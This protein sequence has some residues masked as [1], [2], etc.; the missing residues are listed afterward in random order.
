MRMRVIV[1][2][3]AAL[4]WA[5]G[6]SNG[7]GP[8]GEGGGGGGAT[9]TH[10]GGALV[11]TPVIASR[12]FA[13]AVSS[14]GVVFVG[15]QDAP[16]V[17]V[18]SL[19]G[20]TF[21]DSVRVGSD[22]TDIAFNSAGSVAYV[23]NQ[24]SS[25][26]GVINVVAKTSTDSIA[27]PGSPYRVVV[28][29]AN[30]IVYVSSSNDS[31]YAVSTSSKSIIGRWGFNGPVNGL[32]VSTSGASLY[33]TTMAGQLGRITTASGA[34]DTVPIGGTLQDIAVVGSELFIAVETGV[35]QVR[36]AATLGAIATVPVS[37][38]FGLKASPDG[39]RLYATMPG[40]G[41][42]A[43]VD[44]AAR[45]VLSTLFLGG[46]PRRIA[47]SPDGATALIGNE[48]NVVEVIGA[49]GAGGTGHPQGVL[50]E[51][52]A[53]A[54]R[55]FAV[56]LS[57]GGVA[58]VGRQDVPFLQA[59]TIP[60]L[61]F[62][63]SIQVGADPTDI[64]FNSTG[65]AAYVTNQAS[66]NLGVINV[67]AKTSTDSIAIPGSPYRVLVGAGDSLV[68]VSSSN[69]SV[70]AISAPAKSIVARWGFSGPVNGLAFSTN[71]ASL[72]VTTTA[73]QLGR[74]TIS[75]G[76]SDTVT[77]GGT[78]QDVAV[79]GGELFIAVEGGDIQVRNATTLGALSTVAVSG[80]FGL[81]A[82]PDGLR[83]YATTTGSGFL[84]VVDPGSREVVGK[85]FLGGL[86]RR[87]AFSSDGS[88]AIIGNESNV[89]DVIR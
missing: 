7:T 75:S 42:L 2:L 87:I 35:I 64:A 53:I 26:L 8:G 16:F 29:P 32:A 85:L 3:V 49:A 68:Y 56:A 14:T 28:A 84:D 5:I 74:I 21:A 15:R 12:P 41:R 17:Q 4:I 9:G 31:V 60:S 83:L 73:G 67:A 27:I 40:A 80:A 81:K 47:F 46:L 70:Y 39:L 23:T 18:A 71:G 54:S 58:L 51:T 57:T 36:D 86:P 20:L 82:S 65:T 89:I 22:P 50:V 10:P 13:V 55:P 24:A 45:S 34:V 52:P 33:V 79:V 1:P 76:T 88:T 72:Y 48:A 62:G 37:G 19:P 63:D 38:A 61:T 11:G 77:I 69:D 44:P 30:T 43:I 78:L 59:T 6:C 66:S 25:N